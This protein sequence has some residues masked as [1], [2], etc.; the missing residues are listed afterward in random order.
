MQK[1]LT[2]LCA[3]SLLCLSASALADTAPAEGRAV[4]ERQCARCHD[5]GFSGLMVRAPRIGSAYWTER[6][7]KLGKDLLVTHTLRGVGRMAAQGGPGG[8][9]EDEARAAVNHILEAA[10]P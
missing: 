7:A 6:E 1:I 4:Y 10:K 5:G 9:S 2:R 8:V 3:S